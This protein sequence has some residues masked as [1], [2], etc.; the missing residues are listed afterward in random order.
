LKVIHLHH[1]YDPTEIDP[2]PIVLA[3]GFFDGVHRGHQAVIKRA[4]AIATAKGLPLAVMTFNQHPAIVFKQIGPDGIDYLSP[5]K[6]KIE[7]MQANQV[8]LL[9]VVDF[10]SEFASLSPKAF[11]NQYMV[12]L[13]A[14]IV[15]AGFDYTYGQKA[16]ANMT[17]LP[18]LSQGRFET[19]SVAEQDAAAAKI[20][21]SRIRQLLLQGNVDQANTLLGYTYQTAGLV[22]HG[23]ARGRTLGYPT[24]NILTDDHQQIPGVG[25]YAVQ[26]QVNGHWYEAMASVGY[27]ITFA[28]QHKLTVEINIFDFDTFIYGESVRICWYHYLRGEVKFENAQGLITQLG[29]DKINTRQYF[30]DLRRS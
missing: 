25:I 23:L 30:E 7:L 11:V 2:E 4:R 15:V 1:P 5:L 3:L 19:V 16:E 17:T 24:A 10:T 29:Q 9:Y 8:D 22:V 6:R 20:S 21:S 28:D 12:N 13:H 27:N 14:Q 18:H 26:I